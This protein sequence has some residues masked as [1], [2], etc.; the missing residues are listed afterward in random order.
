MWLLRQSIE[1]WNGQGERQWSVPDLIAQADG[2]APPDQ[3][4]DVDQEDLMLP[5]NLP[6]LINQQRRQGGS[7]SAQRRAT[8]RAGLYQPYSAQSCRALRRGLPRLDGGYRPTTAT[9]YI[10]GGGSRNTLLNRLTQEATGLEVRCGYVESTTD[11]QL[12]NPVG[13]WGSSNSQQSGDWTLGNNA[14]LCNGW[15]AQPK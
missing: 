9:L 11:W 2:L 6:A 13:C 14:R 1:H 10:V 3:V 5:G 15:L 8:G 7:G 12:R 4:F